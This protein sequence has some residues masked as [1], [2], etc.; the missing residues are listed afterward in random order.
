MAYLRN[1]DTPKAIST[2]GD[3]TLTGSQT[4]TNKTFVAPALGTPASGAIPTSFLTGNR[5]LQTHY[6]YKAPDI[7]A[8]TSTGND[9]SMTTSPM[10]VYTDTFDT[11]SAASSTWYVR[12]QCSFNNEGGGVNNNVSVRFWVSYND[13]STWADCSPANDHF[14]NYMEYDMVADT[15]SQIHGSIFI[16]ATAD[17]GSTV[18]G[19]AFYTHEQDNNRFNV[20]TGQG[21]SIHVTQFVP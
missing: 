6:G 2:S 18:F 8:V 3:V 7:P 12:G 21:V 5:T 16:T 19:A 14:G 1:K 10:V 13:K 4:L 9:N 11:L 15:Y 20:N 17:E